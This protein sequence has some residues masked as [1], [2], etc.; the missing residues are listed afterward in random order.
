MNLSFIFLFII[1]FAATVVVAGIIR[2]TYIRARILRESKRSFAFRNFGL[3]S[4]IWVPLAIIYFVLAMIAFLLRPNSEWAFKFFVSFMF[5]LA[6]FLSVR[7]VI[8]EKGIF[9]NM[10][11][12]SWQRFDGYSWFDDCNLE[13]LVSGGRILT[14][15]FRIKVPKELVMKVDKLLRENIPLRNT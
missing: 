2:S 14:G 13:L 11:L 3:L 9:Y 8:S 1:S 4:R 5:L 7:V 15:K 10:N 12:F 6:A